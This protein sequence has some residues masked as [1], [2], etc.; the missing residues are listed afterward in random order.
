MHMDAPFCDV[1]LVVWT[2]MRFMM[3]D[4]FVLHVDASSLGC[5][6]TWMPL[7]Y[8]MCFYGLCIWMQMLMQCSLFGFFI[9]LDEML[10]DNDA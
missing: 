9:Y 8:F 6:G 2:W 3:C 7:V 10:W 4:M 5:L 1:V